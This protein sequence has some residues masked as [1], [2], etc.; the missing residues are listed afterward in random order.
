MHVPPVN[1][2]TVVPLTEHTLGVA[3]LYDTASPDD[4]VAVGLMRNVF[5]GE[6]WNVRMPTV[7]TGKVIVCDPFAM[8][9][10]TIWLSVPPGFVALTVMLKVPATVGVPEMTLFERDIPVGMPEAP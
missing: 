5:E 10:E 4:E 7:C 9:Y 2:V 1:I 3:E 8:V 6:A